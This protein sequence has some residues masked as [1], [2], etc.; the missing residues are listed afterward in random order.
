M[1]NNVNYISE[2]FTNSLTTTT[3]TTTNNNNNNNLLP[4]DVQLRRNSY[5]M[6]I[7]TSKQDRLEVLCSNASSISSMIDH[8][9]TTRS[10]C[11]ISDS[12]SCR[13][14]DYIQR[15]TSQPVA[16]STGNDIL[17]ENATLLLDSPVHALH[18]SLEISPLT[19]SFSPSNLPLANQSSNERTDSLSSS[20]I[21]IISGHRILLLRSFASVLVLACLFSTEVLQT[22]FY[23]MERSFQI[24][25]T[26][27][28]SSSISAL[29]LAA[30]TSHTQVNRY[31]WKI[32]DML[33]YDRCSQILI[34]FTTIFTSTW[35][36]M[37]YFHSFYYCLLISASITGVCLSCMIIKT[38]DHLLQLSATLPFEDR[39]LLTERI[40]L[41][42]CIYNCICHLALA[43]GGGC[44]LVVILFQQWK[45]SYTLI[46]SQSCIV[47]SCLQLRDQQDDNKQFLE[48]PQSILINLNVHL[49]EK[50]Q[51]WTNEPTRYIFFISLIIL[52]MISLIIQIST[53]WT[54]SV[55][56][57]SGRLS[58]FT[59][60]NKDPVNDIS[61]RIH[62]KYYLFALFIGFQEGYVFGNIIKFDVTCLYGL[63]YA[64]EMLI[65]YGLSATI[66]SILIVLIIKH[67]RTMTCISFTTL[68][69]SIT[70]IIS[71]FT[72]M[73]Y[74]LYNIDPLIMKYVLFFSYGI[75]LGLWSTILIY[76][77]CN[78]MKVFSS[79]TF[80]KSLA[81]RYL[82][83]IIAYSCAVLLCQSFLFYVD[84]LCLL[85]IFGFIC[86]SYC[87]CRR[88]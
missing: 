65:I 66:S 51:I 7:L 43:I 11:A 1:N 55:I 63:R 4:N 16:R 52:M 77:V 28:L 45:Y 41:F 14:N 34:V 75:V 81:L 13:V 2:N 26:L 60:S 72:R 88:Q 10:L 30:Y 57:M 62:S 15:R 36:I 67:M 23:S 83:R 44:F 61:K 56:T 59:Y 9:N 47:I 27:H 35:I 82:G 22:S 8:I 37:Q 78:S 69:H 39:N 29:S 54:T 17:L 87:C 70:I 71:Y 48:P 18:K 53:E 21:A 20:V 32:S 33:A 85:C 46:G 40:K 64:A 3:T 50:T 24:L 12:Y 73:Q 42:I 80:A 76:S 25:L 31:R 58:I 86:I 79:S 38:V 74:I 84:T 49:G 19:K 6:A 5:Q 68:L